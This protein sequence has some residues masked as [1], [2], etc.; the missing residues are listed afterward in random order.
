MPKIFVLADDLTG[1]AEIGGAAYQCGLSVRIILD[2]SKLTSQ[3]QDVII[4]DSN[5]R[6]LDPE[7]AYRHIHQL[8][9]GHDFSGY[10][11][12][13]MKVDSVMRGPIVSEIRTCMEIMNL[14]RAILVEKLTN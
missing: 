5:S 9:T 4:L 11:F 12:V 8:L 2:T 13:F 7:Q 3:L 14:E 10:D 6:N 1:A